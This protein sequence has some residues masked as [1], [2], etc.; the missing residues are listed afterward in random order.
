MD[1]GTTP[2]G[3]KMGSLKEKS[4]RKFEQ[5]QS[6][7]LDHKLPKHVPQRTGGRNGPP[8]TSGLHSRRA[9]AHHAALHRSTRRCFSWHHFN[10]FSQPSR[11]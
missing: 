6:T 8:S 10:T 4:S 11:R 1:G 9:P 7:L 2:L 3:G 5:K